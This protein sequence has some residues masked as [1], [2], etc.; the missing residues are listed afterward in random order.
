MMLVRVDKSTMLPPDLLAI[1]CSYSTPDVNV[2]IAY[3]SGTPDLG[4]IN[5]PL[6]M[7]IVPKEL[8]DGE[9]KVRTKKYENAPDP[10]VVCREWIKMPL[11]DLQ[12]SSILN[13][14]GSNDVNWMVFKVCKDEFEFDYVEFCKKLSISKG[15]GSEF[16]KNVHIFG[17]VNSCLQKS[18]QIKMIRVSGPIQ[19]KL[20]NCVEKF[21][22]EELHLNEQH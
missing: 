22:I 17:L 16:E 9:A 1:V 20:L 21:K 14:I 18:K 5:H 4:L 8:R 10:E 15:A 7:K 13:I 19:K 2:K 6:S 11:F 12:E 3:V